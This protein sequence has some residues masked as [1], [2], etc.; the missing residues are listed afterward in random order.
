MGRLSVR[1]VAFGS[2]RQMIRRPTSRIGCRARSRPACDPLPHPARDVTLPAVNFSI[3]TRTLAG[4]WGHHVPTLAAALVVAGP[5][6][7][8]A[9]GEAP[10]VIAL[11]HPAARPG[12]TLLVTDTQGLFALGEAAPP[13]WLCEDAV[14]PSAGL[15]GALVGPGA[16][17]WLVAASAGLAR[18]TDGGCTF[19]PV[20]GAPAGGTP[21]GLTAHPMRPAERVVGFSEAPGGLYFSEDAGA[22]WRPAETPGVLQV[23]SLLRV[24]AA[25]ERLYAAGPEGLFRSDDG[26]RRYVAVTGGGALEGV[27]PESVYV[28]AGGG[29]PDAPDEV[30]VAVQRVPAS[31]LLRS[32][33]RGETFEG[34]HTLPDPIDSLAFD[35]AGERALVATIFGTLSRSG[36]GFVDWVDA[37]APGPGFGRLVRGPAG[38]DDALWACADAYQG[39]PF[40]VAKSLDFGET[41]TPVLSALSRVER[42][43]DCPA[44]SPAAIACADVC[45]GQPVGGTCLLCGAGVPCDPEADADGGSDA[46]PGVDDGGGADPMDAGPA[47]SAMPASPDAAIVGPSAGATIREGTCSAVGRGPLATGLAVMLLLGLARSRR[48]STLPANERTPLA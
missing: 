23:R 46:E 30:W 1:G 36:P 18:S 32:R 28:L 13:R 42:R 8:L 35:A 26:G 45:P 41:W 20:S 16:A 47:S 31:L 37:P 11:S 12:M 24:A 10:R 22:S 19:A 14:A 2:L 34:V 25:P 7:A 5:V 38:A 3:R 33:D 9:H 21:V 29:R 39:A 17:E 43:F 44:D 48:R 15:T 6:D 40:T 27:D 4:A